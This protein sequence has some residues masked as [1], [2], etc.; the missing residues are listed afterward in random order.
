MKTISRTAALLALTAATF[1]APVSAADTY[2]LDASHTAITFHIDHFGFSKPS[3]KFM[4]VEGTVTLDEKTPADSKVSVSIPVGMINTGVAKL[5]EHLK[6][7]DFFDVEQFPT[8]TFVSDKVEV[9]DAT[10]ATVTGLLTLHGVSK[11]VTLDVKLNKI[12]ENMMKKQT[13]G[14]TASTTLKRSDF[15][16]TNYLP[17]LGD[18]VRIEIESEANK[19]DAAP[20]EKAK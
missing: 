13:A 18:D 16:I 8:A 4:N 3:G 1:A 15:G 6:G 19:E 17:N 20:A 9:K 12:A 11:P 14:F 7:K 10:S 5:D 2:K